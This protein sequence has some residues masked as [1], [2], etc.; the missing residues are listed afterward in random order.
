MPHLSP[1]SKQLTPHS[2]PAVSVYVRSFGIAPCRRSPVRAPNTFPSP[3][4]QR[5][6]ELR[7]HRDQYTRLHFPACHLVIN[8]ISCPIALD[9]AAGLIPDVLVVAAGGPRDDDILRSGRRIV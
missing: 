3:C 9:A 6:N 8:L 4:H 1:V 7:R 2:F 5:R